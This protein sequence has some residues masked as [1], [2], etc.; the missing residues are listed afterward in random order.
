[1]QDDR[2]GAEKSRSEIGVLVGEPEI[3]ERPDPAKGSWHVWSERM[4]G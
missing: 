3:G 1:M 4:K 2:G